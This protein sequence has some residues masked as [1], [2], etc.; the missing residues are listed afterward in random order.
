M[1][2]VNFRSANAAPGQPENWDEAAQGAVGALPIAVV[3]LGGGL[4]CFYSL[5]KPDAA[6]M[7]ALLGGGAV[8]L[9]IVGMAQHPVVNMT[10]LDPE[11][12]KKE[13]L[14]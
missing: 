1:R 10:V 13:E 12:V 2:F 14:P 9:G 5:W 6:E 11:T 4:P 3:D 7:L 8:R